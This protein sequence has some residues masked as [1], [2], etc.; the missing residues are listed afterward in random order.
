MKIEI[1]ANTDTVANKAAAIIAAEARD[2]VVARGRF[3]VALSGGRTPRLL[4][5]A[6]P[7]P[8]IPRGHLP[9]VPVGRPIPPPGHP[10]P[11]LTHFREKL[12][13]PGP[14]PPPQILPL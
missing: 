12:R 5:R 7:R 10:H 8:K 3:V 9:I 1:L 6:P 13:T 11:H 2:A 4:F 14:L